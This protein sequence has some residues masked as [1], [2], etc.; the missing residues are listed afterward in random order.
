MNS[1]SGSR[2][3]R[4]SGRPDGALNRSGGKLRSSR[5]STDHSSLE[6]SLTSNPSILPGAFNSPFALSIEMTTVDLSRCRT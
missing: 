6:L 3:V 4:S 2:M 5:L 1:D